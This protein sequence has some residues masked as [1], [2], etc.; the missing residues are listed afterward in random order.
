MRCAQQHGWPPHV[1]D[2]HQIH[3]GRVDFVKVWQRAWTRV[4]RMDPAIQL[5]HQ[6]QQRARVAAT[7]TRTAR[8][9]M[10]VL[11]LNFR[12]W[13]DRPTSLPDPRGTIVISLL[14]SASIA[15]RLVAMAR[16]W[17]GHVRFPWAKQ[18]AEESKGSGC[19]Q[20]CDW[21]IML[22][23]GS[24][25]REN[26]CV[27]VQRNITGRCTGQ[28]CS[29]TGAGGD[30]VLGRTYASIAASGSTFAG[31]PFVAR[32][33]G[34]IHARSR[35]R[36]RCVA[37]SARHCHL[38]RAG[39]KGNPFTPT[40]PAPAAGPRSPAGCPASPAQRGNRLPAFRLGS[41]G[42]GAHLPMGQANCNS[43]MISSPRLMTEAPSS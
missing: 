24:K 18:I 19:N 39:H 9:T 11:P 35:S 31:I 21:T 3:L 34:F 36:E 16:R 37:H 23:L 43:D 4:P 22:F 25:K 14:S 29:R 40:I 6:G 32:V 20:F 42:A 8:R 27:A 41:A 12:M 28:D 7:R 38:P 17:R 1:R 33:A 13:H 15:L 2:E 30:Q 5:Q 10:I 26:G